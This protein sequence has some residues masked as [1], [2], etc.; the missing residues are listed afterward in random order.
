MELIDF[1][2]ILIGMCLGSMA[3]IYTMSNLAELDRTKKKICNL[4]RQLNRISER[5]MF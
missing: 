4:E 5:Y 1:A 3:F 2:F